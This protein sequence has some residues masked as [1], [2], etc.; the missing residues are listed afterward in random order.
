MPN[1]DN[2]EWPD[3]D[4]PTSRRKPKATPAGG[5]KKGSRPTGYFPSISNGGADVPYWNAVQLDFITLLEVDPNIV[6]FVAR[7]LEEEVKVLVDGKPILRRIGFHLRSLKYEAYVDIVRKP[8]PAQDALQAYFST[9]GLAYGWMTEAAIALEPRLS[10]ARK[11]LEGACIEI[12]PDLTHMVSG[13]IGR[14]ASTLGELEPFLH[15]WAVQHWPP[16][17]IGEL[18]GRKLAF[19][20]HL[21]RKIRID[22]CRE[23]FSAQTPVEL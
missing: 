19:G 14:G 23:P 5:R 6:S 7:P 13:A 20:L 4:W 11:M 3:D 2:I 17:C 10:N 16:A 12:P 22:Y 21:R 18:T 15:G 8:G 9:M 1:D